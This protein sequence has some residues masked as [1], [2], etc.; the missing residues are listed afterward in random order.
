VAVEF[1]IAKMSDHMESAQI[2]KWFVREGDRVEKFQVIMEVMTDKV[3]AEL[4]SP[5]AGMIAGIRP[6]AVDGAEV[7][8]GEPICYIAAP[9][10]IVPALP[11]LP[12]YQAVDDGRKT[13]DDARRPASEDTTPQDGEVEEV[14][15]P[16]ASPVARKVAKELGVDLS[17]VKGS[18]PL[19]RVTEADVREFAATKTIDDRAHRT[20]SSAERPAVQAA[21][22]AAPQVPATTTSAY[23][24]R[25][26]ALTPIQRI[27]GERMRASVINAP[28]FALD[29]AVDMSQT[30]W[31]REQLAERVMAEA[32]VK[33]SVTGL[34]VKVVAAAL[35]RHPRA[36]AE[37][38]GD[39]LTLHPAIHIG[40]AV[41]TDDGLVVP[42]IRDAD[43]KSLTEIT[44]ELAAFQ[45]KA[46][47][48]RFSA[49]DLS[50]GTFTVSNLGM[51]GVDGFRAIINPPQSAI[52]A[53]GQIT[54]IPVGLP[55]ES[56]ALR[57]MMNLTLTV[58]HRCMDGVQGARF[59][60]E[61]KTLLEQ[62]HLLLA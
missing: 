15:G 61:I 12:G 22:V 18:G 52:L 30:L 3:T 33:L 55:D 25:S 56:V 1:F 14:A 47:T 23:P 24:Q 19:G 58:D 9:G 46:K 48:L 54:K 32:G 17:T 42:V 62:P 50:G 11:P 13:M 29:V 4:E 34:L 41:G 28:Q 27:T 39:K 10:E 40:V 43:R 26:V 7:P 51:Y 16:R 49:D 6:G 2:L 53:V 21:P 59:L 44:V 31:L 35:K 37:F 45:E 5:E 57:P 8:V 20:A 38:A 36:N 60:A